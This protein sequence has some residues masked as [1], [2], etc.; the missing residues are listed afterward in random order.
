MALG[1]T[2]WIKPVLCE[3]IVT[4]SFSRARLAFV[5]IEVPFDHIFFVTIRLLFVRTP[6]WISIKFW[7]CRGVARMKIFSRGI[8][9][10]MNRAAA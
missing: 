8:L 9:A 3:T 5:E 6:F 4:S 7:E 10:T 1:Y 2:V